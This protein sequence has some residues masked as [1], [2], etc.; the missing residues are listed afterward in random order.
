MIQDT[1]YQIC[2]NFRIFQIVT[3]IDILFAHAFSSLILF[4]I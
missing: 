4:F 2:K 1:V 3:L